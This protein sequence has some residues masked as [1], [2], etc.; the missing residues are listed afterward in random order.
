MLLN[1]S[2]GED[3]WTVRSNQSIL[4]EINPEYSSKDWCWSSNTCTTWCKEP[5]HWKRPWCWDRLKV[6]GEGDNKRRDGGMESL[7]QWTW[8]WA[9]SRIQW[10]TGKP[11]MLHSMGLQ[12]VGHDLATEQQ[13]ET[14]IRCGLWAQGGMNRESKEDLKMV[15]YMLPYDTSC[16]TFVQT[17]RMYNNKLECHLWFWC[18]LYI[19]IGEGSGT[20]LQ[21]SCLENPM[22]GG[23]W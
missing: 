18:L 8:V 15:K 3:S 6:G 7:T 20:P 11:G 5:H 16:Y 23:A 2:A 12:R 19:N 9:N 13:M 17:H 14:L 22:D 1:C 21:Y 4:K 10:R